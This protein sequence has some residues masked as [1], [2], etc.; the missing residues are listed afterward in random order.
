MAISRLC[1]Y[2]RAKLL[3]ALKTIGATDED[4]LKLILD[5]CGSSIGDKFAILDSTLDEGNPYYTVSEL[6]DLAFDV[7]GSFDVFLQAE[8]D[9]FDVGKVEG[10]NHVGIGAEV[11]VMDSCVD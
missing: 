8:G 5:K 9:R 7:E 10:I 1:I 2:D 6:V 11:E 4:R 3:N